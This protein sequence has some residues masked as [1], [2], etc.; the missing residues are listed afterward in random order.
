MNLRDKC[1][2]N[3]HAP[4]A[5]KLRLLLKLLWSFLRGLIILIRGAECWLVIRYQTFLG[6]IFLDTRILGWLK[7]WTSLSSIPDGTLVINYLD[8]CRIQAPIVWI[9]RNFMYYLNSLCCS[10]RTIFILIYCYLL[11]L[12]LFSCC[13]LI[14]F[15]TLRRIFSFFFSIINHIYWSI[16]DAMSTWDRILPKYSQRIH[17]MYECVYICIYNIYH[18]I[19]T[20][21]WW[22]YVPLKKEK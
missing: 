11:L 9:R 20:Y 7:T 14:M 13:L 17:V 6:M 5:S 18:C 2:G 12:N 8:E 15:T 19:I 1:S 22:T 3:M 4:F 10:L 16:Y 21:D